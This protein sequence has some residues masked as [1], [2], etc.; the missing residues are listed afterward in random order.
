[1]T[2]DHIGAVYFPDLLILRMIGRIAFPIFAYQI[3]IGIIFTRSVKSYSRRVLFFAVL[4]QI[5]YMIAFQTL[6]FNVL[7]TF[8]LSIKTISS[9]NLFHKGLFIILASILN[10]EYGIYGILLVIIFYKTYGNNKLSIIIGGLWVILY[11]FKIDVSYQLISILSIVI[12]FLIPA[13]KLKMR[14][15]RSFFYWYYPIHL[16]IFSLKR[17]FGF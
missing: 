9:K 14:L 13:P 12:I 8:Y 17:I 15:S 10:I 6:T 4:A 5:P 16:L 7:F 2:V 3:A 11:V 1:M